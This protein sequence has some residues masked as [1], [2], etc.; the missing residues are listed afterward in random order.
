MTELDA[1]ALL[2]IRDILSTMHDDR[3]GKNNCG[4]S[5]TEMAALRDSCRRITDITARAASRDL[6]KREGE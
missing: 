2:E 6:A 1:D 4:L 5:Q 3:V